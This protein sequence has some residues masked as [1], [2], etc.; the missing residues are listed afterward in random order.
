M[1]C[2][3][4]IT[5]EIALEDVTHFLLLHS[6]HFSKR[7]M[8]GFKKLTSS[9]DGSNTRFCSN[10]SPLRGLGHRLRC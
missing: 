8:R 5:Q 1:H 2:W 7:L 9:T 3:V 10:S 6:N 4:I